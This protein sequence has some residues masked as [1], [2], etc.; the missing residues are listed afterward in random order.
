MRNPTKTVFLILSLSILAGCQAWQVR[1]AMD[2]AV[3]VSGQALVEVYKVTYAQVGSPEG[4]DMLCKGLVD[5]HKDEIAAGTYTEQMLKDDCAKI[6]SD[7]EA[8]FDKSLN[9]SSHAL[10]V[11]ENALYLWGQGNLLRRIRQKER[12]SPSTICWISFRRSST[13]FGIP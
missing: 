11:L 6:I 3:D 5:K 12:R 4:T 10:L 13:Y 1:N 2:Y 8:K 9:A 7:F